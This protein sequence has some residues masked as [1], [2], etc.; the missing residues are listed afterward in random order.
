M[1]WV[2]W[3][4][5]WI[6]PVSC[7]Y[8]KRRSRTLGKECGGTFTIVNI[9]YII[10]STYNDVNVPCKVPNVWEFGLFSLCVSLRRLSN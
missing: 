3:L 6:R 10:S 7:I 9:I 2:D 5:R 4:E 8:V 1:V